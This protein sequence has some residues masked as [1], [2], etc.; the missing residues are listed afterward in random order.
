MCAKLALTI[1]ED[2]RSRVF[3]N[4]V[5][6]IFAPKRKESAGG[7]RRLHNEVL[8]HNLNASPNI[9][10]VIKYRRMKL[11]GHVAHM[12][13]M[14]NGNKFWSENL[15]GR[16]HMEDLHVDGKIILE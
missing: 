13:E 14:R 6:R 12:G 5:L 10:R 4:R 11:T 16:D 9:I 8:D 15:K 7:W 2:Q 3:E 1:K